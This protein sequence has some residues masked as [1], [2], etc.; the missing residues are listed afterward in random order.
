MSPKRVSIYC[1]LTRVTTNGVGISVSFLIP[2][3]IYEFILLFY[4]SLSTLNVCTHTNAHTHTHTQIHLA[5]ELDGLGLSPD[6][7]TN[8][9]SD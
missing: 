8:I 6:I 4:S 1:L 9:V 7:S 3:L 2:F 5:L